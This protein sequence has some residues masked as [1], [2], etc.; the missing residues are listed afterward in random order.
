MFFIY[1][2][3]FFFFLIMKN[4]KLEEIEKKL[5]IEYAEVENE[6]NQFLNKY[7]ALKKEEE[8]LMCNINFFENY[9]QKLNQ[10][11]KENNNQELNKNSLNLNNNLN[12]NLEEINTNLKGKNNSINILNSENF[13]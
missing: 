6:R 11:E 1:N 10:L 13:L 4:M 8:V 3:F 5:K 12:H 7:F 2:Y 9:L